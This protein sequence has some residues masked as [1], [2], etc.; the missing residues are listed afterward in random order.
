MN[1]KFARRYIL[2]R[3]IASDEDDWKNISVSGKFRIL[4]CKWQERMLTCLI[5]STQVRLQSNYWM[6][7][8]RLICFG[9]LGNLSSPNFLPPLRLITAD[10]STSEYTLPSFIKPY[11]TDITHHSFQF[12]S[13]EIS[14]FPI[15]TPVILTYFLTIRAPSW[16]KCRRW[17]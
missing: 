8:N 7:F 16:L 4:K 9:R 6:V 15:Y 2:W 13:L 5:S 1:I 11:F 17:N 12:P 14:Q 3:T 10:C